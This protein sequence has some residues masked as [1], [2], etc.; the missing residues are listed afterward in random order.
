MQR[1]K[2]FWKRILAMP[3]DN[4]AKFVVIPKNQFPSNTDEMFSNENIIIATHKNHPLNIGK[5]AHDKHPILIDYFVNSIKDKFSFEI[6]PSLAKRVDRSLAGVLILIADINHFSEDIHFMMFELIK[7]FR[8]ESDR[9][10]IEQTDRNALTAYDCMGSMENCVAIDDATLRK[11]SD[12]AYAESEKFLI[13]IFN[14]LRQAGIK[15]I[16]PNGELAR[17]RLLG[18]LPAPEDYLGDVK[19]DP[20]TDTRLRTS[21]SK[22]LTAY[23]S[24]NAQVDATIKAR[25]KNFLRKMDE[26]LSELTAT[27]AILGAAHVENLRDRVL[28]DYDAIIVCPNEYAL[29]KTEKQLNPRN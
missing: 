29:L 22:H 6:S 3:A 24:Y 17:L 10:L 15:G 21:Y 25:D 19:L 26:N 9:L 7:I 13:E 12:A 27:Y 11:E 8:R 16:P 1:A 4:H 28:L 18:E 20:E 2:L 23:E 14:I 5:T